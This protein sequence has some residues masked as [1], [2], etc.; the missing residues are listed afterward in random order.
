[1]SSS[2]SPWSNNSGPARLV[3]QV[4]ITQGE[5]A[6]T[7]SAAQA[8]LETS[9]SSPDTSLAPMTPAAS[10]NQS[11][12]EQTPSWY[13]AVP[14]AQSALSRVLSPSTLE[15]ASS[16]T[17]LA[18]PPS[19]KEAS[20]IEQDPEL[21]AKKIAEVAASVADDAAKL[22]LSDDDDDD[23]GEWTDDSGVT[24]SEG[25]IAQVDAV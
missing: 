1:M 18:S 12:N 25:P 10:A 6:G 8:D 11:T 4:V 17:P 2:P 3:P 20:M 19:Y 15:D 24:F 22:D 21:E 7:S 13:I 9:V 16:F 23:D 5:S 14:S